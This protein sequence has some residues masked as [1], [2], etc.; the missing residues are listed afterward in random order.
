VEPKI[1]RRRSLIA[2]RQMV[3][4]T[5]PKDGVVDRV[6][7]VRCSRGGEATGSGADKIT[8]RSAWS[9]TPLLQPTGRYVS[10]ES[11]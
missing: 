9:H 6:S 1:G 11:G 2:W 4:E 8:G 5:E 3:A 10:N 7:A